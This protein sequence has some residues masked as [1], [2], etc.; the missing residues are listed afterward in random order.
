MLKY[1]SLGINWIHSGPRTKEAELAYEQGSGGVK[2][3]KQTRLNV[4]IEGW[5]DLWLGKGVGK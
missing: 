5:R 3:S 1:V 4:L 2:H